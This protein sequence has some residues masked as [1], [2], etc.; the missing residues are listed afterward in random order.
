MPRKDVELVARR[1]R[2]EWITGDYRVYACE[3]V[4]HTASRRRRTWKLVAAC[5]KKVIATVKHVTTFASVNAHGKL[6]LPVASLFTGLLYDELSRIAFLSYFIPIYFIAHLNSTH[7]LPLLF[8][9]FYFIIFCFVLFHCTISSFN[10]FSSIPF[11]FILFHQTLIILFY[12]IS[13]HYT[14]RF[15]SFSLTLCHLISFRFY[16]ILFRYF[17]LYFV[18]YYFSFYSIHFSS[19]LFYFSFLTLF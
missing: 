7:F 9:L 8:I 19:F 11:Y 17:S 12:F 14:S 1:R 6:T 5:T 2:S 18:I 16:F 4:H 15:S 3:G 10:S 13:L